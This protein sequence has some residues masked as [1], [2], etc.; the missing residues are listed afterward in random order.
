MYYALRN[1]RGR[2]GEKLRNAPLSNAEYFYVA[3][4]LIGGDYSMTPSIKTT[5]QLVLILKLVE[6]CSNTFQIREG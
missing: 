1:G 6:L 3:N 4:D 5:F 2:S